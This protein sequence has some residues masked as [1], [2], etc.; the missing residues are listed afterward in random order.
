[1][2]FIKIKSSLRRLAFRCLESGKKSD[3]MGFWTT[4]ALL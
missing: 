3:C 2:R 4:I 1:M